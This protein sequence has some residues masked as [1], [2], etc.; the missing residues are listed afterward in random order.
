M[1]L[2]MNFNQLWVLLPK[3]VPVTG[4]SWGCYKC[5]TTSLSM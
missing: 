2:A 3:I 1:A 4:L 5:L